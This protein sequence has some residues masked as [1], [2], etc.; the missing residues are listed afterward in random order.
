MECKGCGS[1]IEECYK[2]CNEC[3]W[4]E[5]ERIYRSLLALSRDRFGVKSGE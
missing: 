3:T 1:R 4:K 2:L 5:L